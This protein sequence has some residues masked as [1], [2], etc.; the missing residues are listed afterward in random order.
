LL[1][2]TYAINEFL[3]GGGSAG[4]TEPGM[5]EGSGQTPVMEPQAEGP[6]RARMDELPAQP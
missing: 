1:L 6:T 2:G 5:R 4:Q 3:N